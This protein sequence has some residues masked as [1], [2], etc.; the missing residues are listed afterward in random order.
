MI[1]VWHHSGRPTAELVLTEEER[2]TLTRWARRRDQAGG[3]G[4][5]DP[6]LRPVDEVV[7]DVREG[8]V[9]PSAARDCYGVVLTNVDG[10]WHVDAA[11]TARLRRDG[12]AA[13]SY[14]RKQQRS[15]LG[16]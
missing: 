15:G 9:S 6:L 14:G 11:E 2:E 5:G 16:G 7:A 1:R 13:V 12:R 4:Y 10:E 3:R 8:Y